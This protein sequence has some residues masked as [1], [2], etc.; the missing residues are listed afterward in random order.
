MNANSETQQ[1]ADPAPLIAHINVKL[2][3]LGLE[4]VKWQAGGQ[5]SDLLVALA[6]HTRKKTGCLASISAPPTSVSRLF[7]TITC[8]K[9]RSPSCARTFTLDRAGLARLLSLPVDR[10]EF[11]SEIVSSYRVQQGV[12]HNP[13]ADRRTTQGTFHIAE[14]GLAIPDDKLAVPK[15]TFARMLALA[16]DP[17]RELLRLPFTA[18]QPRPAECFVS[19]LIRPIVCPEAPGFTAEKTMEIKV[20][21]ARQ[22]GEQP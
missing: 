19:L 4:P 6:A 12:L 16:L 13:K 2:A 20:L 14:G 22:P 18:T 10:D 5:S 1:P 7:S 8:R 21:R 9:C 11:T 17:P 3:L 15:L